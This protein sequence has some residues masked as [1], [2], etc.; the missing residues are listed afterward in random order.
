M[1]LEFNTDFFARGESLTR[2]YSNM[3]KAVEK[4]AENQYVIIIC[5]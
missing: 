3:L 5:S 2:K 4:I 1:I